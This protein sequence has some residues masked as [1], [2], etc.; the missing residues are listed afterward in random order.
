[1][2][3]HPAFIKM[4]RAE[5]IKEHKELPKILR[6]NNKKLREKEAKKQEQEGKEL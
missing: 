4:S 1:M 5:L 6:S 3:N 2:A